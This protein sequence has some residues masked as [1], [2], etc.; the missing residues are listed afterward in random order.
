MV[1]VFL[2]SVFN[3]MESER[4]LMMERH[5]VLPFCLPMCTLHAMSAT[6]DAPYTMP[7]TWLVCYLLCASY[8]EPGTC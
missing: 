7:G 2:S 5:K 4:K 1:T 3:G 8:A 6:T